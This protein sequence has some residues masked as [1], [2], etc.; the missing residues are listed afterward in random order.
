MVENVEERI[1]RT[2][3][4]LQILDIVDN[5]GVDALVEME[6]AVDVLR[7]RGSVLALEKTRGHVQHAGLRV[8]FLYA[9]AYSLDKVGFA[10]T[11]GAENEQRV[12]GL[13]RGIVADGFTDAA[14]YFVALA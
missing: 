12:E 3:H 1:L 7:C 6:E 5:Q 9:Y 2:G 14:C 4:V 10:H 13:K 11:G 8:A